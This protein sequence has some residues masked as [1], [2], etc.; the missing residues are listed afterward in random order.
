[1]NSREE[2]KLLPCPFCGENNLELIRI[3]NEFTKSRRAK[4]LCRNCNLPMTVGAIS[5]SLDWCIKKVT[6]KWNTRKAFFPQDIEIDTEK[7]WEKC[8]QLGISV[9][10]SRHS[11]IGWIKE[12]QTSLIR[13][14]DEK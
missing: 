1:M 4:V 8:V 11:L 7:I 3:G 2:L 12:N 5:N 13:P 10:E 14:K 6:E 9:E